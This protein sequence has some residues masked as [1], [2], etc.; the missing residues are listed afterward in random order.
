MHRGLLYGSRL[1]G[2][3]SPFESSRRLDVERGQVAPGDDGHAGLLLF[4]PVLLLRTFLI[5]VL[6]VRLRWR[7]GWTKELDNGIEEGD[8][9]TL[10]EVCRHGSYS[11]DDL[12]LIDVEREHSSFLLWDNDEFLHSDGLR[13]SGSAGEYIDWTSL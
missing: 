12:T 7:G 1:G 10:G 11:Y 6:R 5:M 2:G 4:V 13:E 9:T 3:L 8:Y